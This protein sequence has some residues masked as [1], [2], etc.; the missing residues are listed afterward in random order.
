LVTITGIVSGGCV[1]SGEINFDY[2]TFFLNNGVL[3][4]SMPN[5]YSNPFCSKNNSLWKFC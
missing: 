1:I 5:K 4:Q 2:R 3:S